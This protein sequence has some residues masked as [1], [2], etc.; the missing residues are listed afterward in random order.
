MVAG[1]SGVR[2]WPNRSEGPKHSV[3]TSSC[4]NKR[5]YNRA[6]ARARLRAREDRNDYSSQ[7]P[8]ETENQGSWAVRKEVRPG[9]LRGAADH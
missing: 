9:V 3:A 5:T 2:S 7:Y 4:D 6:L 1:G 8:A